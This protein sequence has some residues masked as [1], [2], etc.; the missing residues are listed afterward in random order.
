MLTA[1]ATLALS[2]KLDTLATEVKEADEA[3]RRL[4]DGFKAIAMVDLPQVP[5]LSGPSARV[6]P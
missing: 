2:R 5:V 1:C 6:W 4:L 3:L